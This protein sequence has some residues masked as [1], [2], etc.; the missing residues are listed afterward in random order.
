MFIIF[1]GQIDSIFVVF[2]RIL[3]LTLHLILHVSKIT[4]SGAAGSSKEVYCSFDCLTKDIS[5]EEI[6]RFN[7]RIS[8]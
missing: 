8:F 1:L 3:V 2:L 7:Y 4:L 6:S 5:H